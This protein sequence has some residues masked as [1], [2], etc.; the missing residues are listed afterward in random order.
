[1][2]LTSYRVGSSDSYGA[3]VESGI[4]DLRARLPQHA[5]LRDLIAAD[6]LKM[7]GEAVRGAAPDHALDVRH[8]AAAGAGAGEDLVHRRQLRR[9]Q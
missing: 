7:A 5:T 3:V 6:A 8:A 2:R 1:M 9:A 4:V